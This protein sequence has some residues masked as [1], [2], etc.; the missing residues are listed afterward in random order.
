LLRRHYR[1]RVF[2]AGAR[3]ITELRDVY[4]SLAATTAA[5]EDAI[6]AAFALAGEPEGLAIM[7]LGRL[8]SGE[9]DVLSDAD[10]LFVC[11]KDGDRE[12]LTRSAEQMIQ[13]LAAY[14]RDGMAFPVDA[15]LRPR[16]GEGELLVTPVHL[17][18]YFEQEVQSWEALMYTKLRFLAGSRS[19]G[20]RAT[21]TVR[22]LFA[23]FAVDNSFPQSVREMRTKLE[24]VDAP[25]K[26]FKTSPGAI[27]D[28]DFLT[29]FLLVKHG[30]SN[31]LG[32]LRDRLW[33]C[34][35]AG[36]LGKADAG[37]LDHAA[38]LLR[39]VEHVVR[40]VVG[41]ARKWLPATEHAQ[42]VTERL[43][44]EILRREFPEGLEAELVR[45]CVTVREI[46]QRILG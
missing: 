33:R 12:S 34:V 8:G 2:T 9:F 27:Y 32:S 14:T 18:A 20:E 40:L 29:G 42:Q 23:R 21:A 36:A 37:A 25:E 5:A 3:D 24:A 46:Y 44:S 43:T 31:K 28:I 1:H 10:L 15:R 45:T 16:G 39:T 26:S 4:E 35:D 38:E 19:L 17:A 7:A 6:A 13:S 22:G 11:G 41:R 30:M